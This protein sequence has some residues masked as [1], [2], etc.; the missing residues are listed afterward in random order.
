M[1][2]NRFPFILAAL[3]VAVIGWSAYHPAEWTVWWMEMVW[4]LGVFA[5]LAATY[6]K[7]RF[8]NLA[9]GIVFIWLVMHTVGAHYT[10]EHVPMDWLKGLLGTERNHY[11]RIAHFSIG[12]NS[13]LLAE[14][15]L[16][17]RWVANCRVAAVVG[18]LGIM[19]MAAGWE[20]IEWIVAVQDGGEDGL[21]FLGSQ[22]DIWDAQK[23]MLAD[24][25]GAI[26]AAVFFFF[27]PFR[28]HSSARSKDFSAS[29]VL[30]V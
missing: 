7:F 30:L 2:T 17:R 25:L 18:V 3:L 1:K 15:A 24:T 14:L 8:S 10:F 4:V 23:D 27:H 19:A 20:I 29:S 11:D 13:Y 22:G 16:R 28:A 12:L 9:Y 6:R 21:A 26:F 5:A